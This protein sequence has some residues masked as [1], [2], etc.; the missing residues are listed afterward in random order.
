MK[1]PRPT[2]RPSRPVGRPRAFETADDLW[3]QFQAYREWCR[4]PENAIP[5]GNKGRTIPRPMTQ[6][7]FA[8][9][10]GV[11]KATVSDLKKR[12]D[13]KDTWALCLARIEDD[14]ITGGMAKLYDSQIVSRV[15]GLVDRQKVETEPSEPEQRYDFSRLT[16]EELETLTELLEKCQIED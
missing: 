13:L 7:G 3:D 12:D 14:T 5:I 11:G 10:V 6:A 2:Q 8:A 16:A 1:M 9:Y 15:T 4:D